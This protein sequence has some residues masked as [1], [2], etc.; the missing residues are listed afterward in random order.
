MGWSVISRRPSPLS[1][2]IMRIGMSVRWRETNSACRG[3]YL[4][5]SISLP[6][7]SEPLSPA[8][9]FCNSSSTIPSKVFTCLSLSATSRS[10]SYCEVTPSVP[11]VLAG[12]D[13][14]VSS[15]IY[16]L[17]FK[18][19][20]RIISYTFLDN[21][22]IYPSLAL[23]LHPHQWRYRAHP[24]IIIRCAT[25]PP[26]KNLPNKWGGLSLV[27]G[28]YLRRPRVSSVAL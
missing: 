4:L 9:F 15:L 28:A 7:P 14:N 13:A 12:R 18:I 5:L 11:A 21:M 6:W 17:L 26:P 25:T 20:C 23:N 8:S 10:A 1:R 2:T 22:S 19:V 16:F 27:A 24:A 3:K